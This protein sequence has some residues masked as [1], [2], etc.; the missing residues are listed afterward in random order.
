M[1]LQKVFAISAWR[2]ECEVNAKSC[3]AHLH[4]MHNVHPHVV[5]L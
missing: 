2:G 4:V 5:I 3:D 1:L